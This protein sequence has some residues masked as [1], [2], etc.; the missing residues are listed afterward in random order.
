MK[1]LDLEKIIKKMEEQNS[2]I[3][4]EAEEDFKEFEKNVYTEKKR[5][6][7]QRYFIYNKEK[8]MRMWLS[9]LEF[10]KLDK[11]KFDVVYTSD[12]LLKPLT[13][14]GCYGQIKTQEESK[15]AIKTELLVKHLI[16]SEEGY[17]EQLVAIDSIHVIDLEKRMVNG[18]I[19]NVILITDLAGNPQT[20]FG[21]EHKK[22][23]IEKIDERQAW[24]T[25]AIELASLNLDLEL[26]LKEKTPELAAVVT[27]LVEEIK[28]LS[29]EIK[30]IIKWN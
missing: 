27:K 20:Q 14:T 24:K 5:E 19:H 23:K 26:K 18:T 21:I 11:T 7:G 10:V 3:C 29:K 16:E 1:K 28:G 8:K 22:Y 6:D 9:D 2:I 17:K 12:F 30:Y 15:M 25:K 13:T 4:F